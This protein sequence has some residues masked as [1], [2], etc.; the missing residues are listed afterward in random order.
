M[1]KKASIIYFC[2]GKLDKC[3][4]K[5]KFNEFYN[6]HEFNYWK[7]ENVMKKSREI[8]ATYSRQQLSDTIVET[9]ST[10]FNSFLF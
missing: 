8:V 10:Y 2:K 3:G 9:F 4:N 6:F 1:K 5:V 7:H